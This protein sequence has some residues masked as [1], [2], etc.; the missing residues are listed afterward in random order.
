MR[1]NKMRLAATIFAIA[2]LAGGTPALAEGP[3][4]GDR[5]RHHG[6]RHHGNWDGSGHWDRHHRRY[7]YHGRW[8]EYAEAA[9]LLGIISGTIYPPA[10]TGPN[11]IIVPAYPVE[12]PLK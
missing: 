8:I 1:I 4:H 9:L 2:A 10:P 11:I 3:H 6:Y 5:E 12:P 7:W